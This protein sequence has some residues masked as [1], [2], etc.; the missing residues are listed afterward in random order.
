MQL[1]D[2]GKPIRNLIFA[3]WGSGSDFVGE[4]VASHPLT[5][6]H[7]EPLI[8]KGVVQIGPLSLDEA[9]NATGTIKALL[10]CEYSQVGTVSFF[11][12]LGNWSYQ[13]MHI[14]LNLTFQYFMKLMQVTL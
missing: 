6:Y 11:F 2:G 7:N 8:H 14:F 5:F 1:S 3:T 13:V 12:K 4:A 10:N 9:D